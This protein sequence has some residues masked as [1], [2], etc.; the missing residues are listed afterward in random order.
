MGSERKREKLLLKKNR[1]AYFLHLF[2][3]FKKLESVSNKSKRDGT[4]TF[5][6][7]NRKNVIK[8]EIDTKM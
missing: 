5:K 7:Q 6:K 4:K 1:S 3:K 2:E 8:K